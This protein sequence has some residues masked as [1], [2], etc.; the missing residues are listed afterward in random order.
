M[1]DTTPREKL[2]RRG[3]EVL[4]ERGRLSDLT[5]RG[6]AE[7]L[8]TSHRMLIHHFGSRDGYLAAL[9]SDLR[10]QEL[11]ALRAASAEGTYRD[12]L[13]LL[14]EIYLD[15][16]QQPRITAFFYVLGLAV[17]D[18]GTY[19]EFLDSLEDWVALCSEWGER[20]G[21]APQV[22][23]AR[24]QALIW[25]SRGL[26]VKGIATGDVPGALRELREV[27]DHLGW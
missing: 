6:L 21:L 27:I 14:E 8:G 9:L 1:S 12:A 5:L 17:Q 19:R 26:L 22:A 11:A 13:R 4:V 24:A 3:Q 16:A 2:L 15:P 18:P 20:E 25:T 10:R 23:R 7:R